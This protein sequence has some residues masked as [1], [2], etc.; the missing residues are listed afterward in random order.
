[1]DGSF[2]LLTYLYKKKLRHRKLVP[3]VI[4]LFTTCYYY[5]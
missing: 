5:Y 4:S 3:L 2:C 1:M